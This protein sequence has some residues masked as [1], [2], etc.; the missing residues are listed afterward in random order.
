MTAERKHEAA[1]EEF[2]L[3]Q[4][5]LGAAELLLEAGF[6]RIVLSCAYFTVFHAVRARLYAEG[7]QPRTSG[8]VQH[9]WNLHLVRTGLYDASTSRLLVR[10]QKLRLEAD[11]AQAFLVDEAGAREELEAARGLVE[12]IRR[13]LLKEAGHP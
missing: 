4:E 13:E 2:Q 10:L 6:A 12:R 8:G 11:Y 3:A 5:E 9:L 1:A 7:L